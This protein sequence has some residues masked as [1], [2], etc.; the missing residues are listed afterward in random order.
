MGV[1]GL[2]VGK[3]RVHGRTITIRTKSCGMVC[4]YIGK[5]FRPGVVYIWAQRA[6][7]IWNNNPILEL[8]C[9]VVIFGVGCVVHGALI[10]EAPM[11]KC[12][13][14]RSVILCCAVMV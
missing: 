3:G 2:R 4:I 1:Q 7:D 11:R 13:K 6:F 9:P 8:S 14:I 12:R 5:T 10:D